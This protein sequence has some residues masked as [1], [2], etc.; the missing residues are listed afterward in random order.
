VNTKRKGGGD[1]CRI[2]QLKSPNGNPL[3][4]P[5]FSTSAT[6]ETVE[7]CPYKTI[8][9]SKES[10]LSGFPPVFEAIGLR[11]NVKLRLN[12]GPVEAL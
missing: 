10:W 4:F 5:L 7:E 6:S 8:I 11:V 9:K 1:D 3:L 2:F 12:L